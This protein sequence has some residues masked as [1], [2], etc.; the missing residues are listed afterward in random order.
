MSKMDRIHNLLT[1]ERDSILANW[2][3][4]LSKPLGARSRSLIGVE[5]LKRQAGE[6]LQ[7]LSNALAKDY[8]E[9]EEELT[10][11][12]VS[13]YLSGISAHRAKQGFSPIETT[14]FVFGLKE[15]VLNALTSSTNGEEAAIQ[16]EII[17]FGRLIDQ[18][19]LMTFESFLQAR[20]EL[21]TQQSRA[22]LELSTP[23]IKLW[24]SVLIMPLVGVIDTV[25][26]Q[27]HH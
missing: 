25:R 18:M 15:G 5:E 11:D 21:I 17:R 14:L 2:L 22:I 7:N 9:S 3:E 23:V 27:H 4:V 26:S 8:D 20:E 13:T 19:G 10:L 6:L 16:K 1:S 24:E 12:E